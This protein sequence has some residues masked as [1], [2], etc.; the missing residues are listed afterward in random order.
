MGGTELLRTRYV[1]SRRAPFASLRRCE[2]D[3]VPRVYS[4]TTLIHT[5]RVAV[6]PSELPDSLE[7]RLN[8]RKPQP[9]RTFRPLEHYIHVADTFPVS[10]SGSKCTALM[11]E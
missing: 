4:Q 5:G 7:M 6:T 2:P 9:C 1:A 8:C 10:K 11:A 3:Q